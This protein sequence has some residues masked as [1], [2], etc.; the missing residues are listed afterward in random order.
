MPDLDEDYKDEMTDEEFAA[1]LKEASKPPSVGVIV[2][3]LEK[4]L[5]EY[6]EKFLVYI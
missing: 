2:F 1:V 6:R 5:S 3:T 4:L